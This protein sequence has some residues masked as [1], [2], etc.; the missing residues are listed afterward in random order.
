MLA[1]TS[2]HAYFFQIFKH[3]L[4]HVAF[5]HHLFVGN[6]RSG[7]GLRRPYVHDTPEA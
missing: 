3:V 5:D 4:L 7:Q 2:W 1:F 6:V